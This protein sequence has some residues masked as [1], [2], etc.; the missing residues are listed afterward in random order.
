M[1]PFYNRRMRTPDERFANLPGFAWAPRYLEWRGLRAHYLDEGGGRRADGRSFPTLLCLHGEPTWSYLYRRMMPPFLAAGYR[2][3]APDFIGFGRSD[4]PEEEDFYSFSMHRDF[5]L[6]LL[7]ELDLKNVTLAVQDW[8]G[9]L[10][11]TLPMEMPERFERLLVMNTALGTGDVPLS[12]GFLAWRAY[13]NK[14]PAIDCGKLLART[15]PHLTPAEAAAY[16][17]PFPDA[18]S[19]AGVRRFPN[20]VPDRPDAPGAALSRQARDWLASAW[21][22]ESFM[23]IG[24]KDPV[25]GPPVMRALRNIIRGCPQPW[26]HAEGGHFLQEWG[27]D[28]ARAALARWT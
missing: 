19:K 15:C 26:I 4:K 6:H 5:L 18:A 14:N 12:E 1:G 13:V 21:K 11:L 22:G 25:L 3:V 9:L 16:E 2:V 7:E 27:E 20:L 17:A 8:G 10:G 23:A 28:V 24:A